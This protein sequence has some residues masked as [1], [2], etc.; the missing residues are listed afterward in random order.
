MTILI[1][2]VGQHPNGQ[3]LVQRKSDRG[4]ML[5]KIGTEEYYP[6]PIDVDNAPW[7]Y[8]ESEV[9]VPPEDEPPAE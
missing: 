9:P 8:E 2:T 6:D 7:T 4:V 1:R 3:A 5:H